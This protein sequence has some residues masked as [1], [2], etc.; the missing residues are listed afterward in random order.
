VSVML[1][2]VPAKAGTQRFGQ[3]LDARFRGHE[4]RVMSAAAPSFAFVMAGLVPAIHV[5]SRKKKDVDARHKA[6]HDGAS[7]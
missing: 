5:C 4:R 2:L 6:G 7:G 1:P 3:G